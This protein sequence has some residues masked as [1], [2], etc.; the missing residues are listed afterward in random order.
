MA[1]TVITL[2]KVPLALRG[3]LTK[4]MQEIDTGVYVG[5]F[6]ARIRDNLWKRVCDAVGGGEAT[7]SYTSRNEIGYE[8]RTWNTKRQV[9]DCDG[10][11]L[12]RIPSDELNEERLKPGFSKAAHQHRERFR[13]S[14]MNRDVAASRQNHNSYVVIDIETTGLNEAKDQ[15]LELGA[16]RKNDDGVTYDHHLIKVDVP[17]SENVKNL[18]GITSEIINDQGQDF[19]KAFSS[20]LDF[21]GNYPLVGY[22]ISFDIKFINAALDHLNY[23]HLSNKVIDLMRVVK[24]EQLFLPNYKLQTSLKAYG[25]IAEVP[26]RALDDAKLI[27]Q[28]SCKVKK[29]GI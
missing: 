29:L 6:N 19:R 24:K 28:L 1:F 15:I 26:H 23:A 12:V 10:I 9:I 20:F 22:N 13:T 21:I 8:F 16:V 17:I 3:D 11:P 2:K 5:N 25:I 27:Y 14:S 4:W 7:I 18:T